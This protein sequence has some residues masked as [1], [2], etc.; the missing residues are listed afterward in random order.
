VAGGVASAPARPASPVT[1]DLGW[2]LVVGGLA[3]VAYVRT[4]APGLTAD[5][6]TAL[7]QFIGRAL[8]VAHNPGYPL[9]TLLTHG[10]SWLPFGSLAYRINLFSAV[11]AATAV[12]LSFLVAR[13]LGAGRLP[14]ASGS[15][16]LAFGPVYWSQAVIAE[17]YGLHAALVAGVL[18]AAVTWARTRRAGA[19]FTG[20]ALFALGLGHHTTIVGFAPGLAA[21]ALMTDRRFVLRRATVALT[22]GILAA[23]LLQYGFVLVRSRAPGAYVES[24]ARSLGELTGVMTGRQFQDRLFAFDRRS[25]LGTRVPEL[26]RRVVIP[27]LTF[28]GVLLALTGAHWLCC[29]RRAEAVA[30]VSGAAIVGAFAASYSVVDTPVFLIPSLLVLWILAAVGGERLVA[31]S[32]RSRPVFVVACGCLAALPGWQ[33]ARNLRTVDRSHDTATAVRLDALFDALPSG[34]GIVSEDF[35]VN[36]LVQFKRLGDESGAGRSVRPLPANAEA[37]REHLAGGRAVVAFPKS[38]AMLRAAGFDVA[39]RPVP[40]APQPLERW[41]ARR[42]PGTV[43]AIAVPG[44]QAQ[45]FAA[46]AAAALGRIGVPALAGAR[47]ST[48]IV[49]VG[50]GGTRRGALVEAGWRDIDLSRDR[51]EAVGATGTRAPAAFTAWSRAAEAGIRVGDRD[52]V[53]TAA[54]GAVLAAWDRAGRLTHAA[55]LPEADGF[56]VPFAA[57][58]LSLHR[59]LGP[60][61]AIALVPQSWVEVAPVLASGSAAIQVPAR[62]VVVLHAAGD[63]ALAPRV[64]EQWPERGTARAA[65]DIT[66]DAAAL[67][68]AVRDGAPARSSTHRVRVELRAGD[69]P[70]SVILAFGGVPAAATATVVPGAGA[71]TP[72]GMSSVNVADLLRT[73]EA[74]TEQLLMGR[75]DQSQLIGTGWSEV[76]ADAA[77]PFRWL[78]AARA[79]LVLPTRAPSVTRVQVLALLDDPTARTLGL[80]IGSVET[81]GQPLGPGWRQ[82]EWPLPPGSLCGGVHEAEVVVRG[83]P[84]DPRREAAATIPRI[85]IGEIRLIEASGG[86]M[87]C[88]GGF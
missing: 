23:G 12:A 75:D 2:S 32:R 65:I 9:Y 31:V 77:G 10:V 16:G 59:V 20:V 68:G 40:L 80:R 19:Y 88:G 28:P 57:G 67:A 25:V 81:P 1:A 38:A 56:A 29:R 30:L 71:G 55:V 46:R 14:A 69:A 48:S 44:R 17:V 42:R 86:G 6:D 27:E 45:P 11:C 83:A 60:R 49:I 3:L 58:P 5:A 61:P 36:R 13:G 84:E 64:T 15:L 21:H 47:P 4:L 63:A 43:V 35:R 22:T 66:S 82:Y 62:G 70:A 85:A 72:A 41:L 26:V 7:F 34:A 18:L 39:Y 50:V 73:P 33:A 74:G 53:R 8:G 76:E 51:G 79:R 54:A 52:V 37:V 24:P 87:P 78:R